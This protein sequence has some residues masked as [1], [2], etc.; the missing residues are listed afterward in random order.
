MKVINLMFMMLVVGMMLIV[1]V[2]AAEDDE[3]DEDNA[4]G[5][6][7]HVLSLVLAIVVVVFAFMAAGMFAES[8]GNAMK[9]VGVGM[10]FLSIN[11]GLEELHHFGVSF[12]PDG[13]THSIMHHGFGG[14]GYV[15]LA[16]GFY[17][18]YR[19]AKGVSSDSINK[20]VQ[21][22]TK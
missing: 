21:K 9:M 13:I 18:V 8:L 7:V 5:T 2:M 10:I 20:P 3:H 16:Y 17:K 19:V 1:P 12:L 15:L 14:I 11:N 6:F 4:V 22:E